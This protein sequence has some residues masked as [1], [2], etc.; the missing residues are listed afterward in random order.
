MFKWDLF[1]NKMGKEDLID[2]DIDVLESYT[3]SM[4]SYSNLTSVNETRYLHFKSKCKPKEAVKPLYC[5]KNVD[6]PCKRVVMR[7]LKRS[8]Y[9]SKLYKNAAVADPLANYTL[10]DYGFELIDGY[11]HVEWFEPFFLYVVLELRYLALQLNYTVWFW[12]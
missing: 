3:C 4:F 6:W 12:N 5:L 7:Q 9:I 11:K 2:E 1:I 8:W 10:R